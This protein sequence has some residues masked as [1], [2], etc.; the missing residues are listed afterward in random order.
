MSGKEKRLRSIDGLS[1]ADS[2]QSLGQE[3]NI[4]QHRDPGLVHIAEMT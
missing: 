4:N 2:R 1:M 3:E